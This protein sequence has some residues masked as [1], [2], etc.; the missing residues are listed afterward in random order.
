MQ[1]THQD[2]H[3]THAVLGGK[4]TTN[5]GISGSAM[6][7]HMLS[8]TLYS[9]QRLAVVREIM[10]NAWDSHIASGITDQAIVITTM[11]GK[12]SV[13]DA[14][15]GI[16]AEMFD[17]VYG[18]Y[19]KSTKEN[20]GEQTGGFGLGSKAP[21]AY[22]DHFEVI[23]CRNG[24]KTIYNMSRSS[25]TVGGKPGITPIATIPTTE[26]GIQVS[27]TFKDNVDRS[28]FIRYVEMIARNGEMKVMLDG[29]LLETLPFT[30]MT[31]D[32]MVVD[33]RVNYESQLARL[34][35]R[36]GN[37]IYPI[38]EDKAYSVQYNEIKV[39]LNE[40]GYHAPGSS[41][42]CI[43]FQA[44]AHSIAVTP[45]RE[46]LSMQEHTVAT[47]QKLLTTFVDRLEKERDR[48]AKVVLRAGI[49]EV[50]QAG[51]AS[52]LLEGKKQ[53][54]SMGYMAYDNSTSISKV[55]VKATELVALQVTY[56]YPNTN[57]FRQQDLLC[58]V[59]MLLDSGWGKKGLLQTYRAALGNVMQHE[60]S[61][62]LHKRIAG[63]L[64]T[65]MDQN[66]EMVTWRLW[67]YGHTESYQR[68]AGQFFDGSSL[69]KT[70]VVQLEKAG[71]L[72]LDGYLPYLRNIVVLSNTKS[73]VQNQL[74][75]LDEFKAIGG[76]TFGFLLYVVHPTA[77]KAEEAEKFFSEQ[78][79]TVLDLTK[80]QKAER[81]ARI[82]PVAKV[83]RKK[84]LPC[85][86][87]ALTG[88][89]I[90]LVLCNMSDA[91]RIE[92]PEW[93]TKASFSSYSTNGGS[94]AGSYGSQ[95]TAAIVRL[96]GSTGGIY[97]TS[98]QEKNYIANGAVHLVK[99]VH[100]KV[101]AEIMS[102]QRI[103]EHLALNVKDAPLYWDRFCESELLC[104]EFGLV[105][106]ITEE[107]KLYLQLFDYL[108][109]NCYYNRITYPDLVKA[110]SYASAIQTSPVATAVLDSLRKADNYIDV[111]NTI[112]KLRTSSNLA[113]KSKLL[114]ILHLAMKP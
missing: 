57:E 109:D 12:F 38:Q 84:G 23:S 42:Y 24:E 98:L 76:L 41:D 4:Q 96:F 68:N 99:Y 55:M 56:R 39:Y 48:H 88:K 89:E 10:C 51:K 80:N 91:K 114:E 43:I 77:A 8:A 78:G 97:V 19:G 7:M 17:E 18:I 67:A 15:G 112:Q 46:A 66:K 61:D 26:T 16:P 13:K 14:G 36:Y 102:N 30:T 33:S 20:D 72:S 40:L 73:D 62:W 111:S 74:K 113:L 29:K 101:C 3:I 93:V 94:L 49:K 1:V 28:I 6:F 35:V 60:Q 106:N 83:T 81:A 82:K 9:N 59:N 50:V 32:F 54:P 11:G 37:V 31:E 22:T 44:P 70:T 75:K 34:N 108:K 105:S 53:I 85:V 27:M 58:R 64:L 100:A 71:K 92:K 25:A 65:A 79:F 47:L 95:N 45:S 90:N 21:Y 107:D 5:L 103:A 87:S 110:M 63:P 52:L 86:S 69:F 2:S 104:K